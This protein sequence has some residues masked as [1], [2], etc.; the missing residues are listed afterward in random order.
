M[1]VLMKVNS[2]ET[3]TAVFGILVRAI[4]KQKS[5]TIFYFFKNIFLFFVC[6]HQQ[7]HCHYYETLH[8]G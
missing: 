5:L 6:F 8:N 4:E 3:K 2:K 1:I 7:L